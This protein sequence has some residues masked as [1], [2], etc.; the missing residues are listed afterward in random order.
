MI[1][2]LKEIDKSFDKA[3]LK[4]VDL[5]IAQ[6]EIVSILG[7]SGSGKSTLLNIIAGFEKADSGSLHINGEVMFNKKKNIVPQERN[8]GFVFQNYALF[9]HL[10]I[11]KNILFGVKK[12]SDKRVVQEMLELVELQGYEKKYPHELSGGEQQRISLA[13]VLATNPDIILLDEPFSSIDVLLKSEIEKELLKL[14]KKSGKTAIFVTH[15]PKEAMAIS[16]K[17]AFIKDGE[18][19]QY[20]T[21]ENIYYHPCSK[22]VASFFGIANFIEDACY[23]LNQITLHEDAGMYRVKLEDAIFRGEYYEL[24]I[25]VNVQEKEYPFTVFDYNNFHT[26]KEF[27]ISIMDLE[28]VK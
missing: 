11:E 16:D 26:K 19:V 25:L 17:I 28:C 18:I 12:K 23:R 22:E 27:Y 8:I 4:E 5:E 6:G 15:D 24:Q 9:P 13:R 21:P 20:D 10:S 7:Q 14:I 3:V 1:L 2:A